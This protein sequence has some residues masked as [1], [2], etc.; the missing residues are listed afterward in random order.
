MVL[1]VLQLVANRNR[2]KSMCNLVR[3][4]VHSDYRA[5]WID[6]HCVG[7]DGSRKINRRVS[8]AGLQETV[9]HARTVFKIAH[10]IGTG[11]YVPSLCERAAG[12]VK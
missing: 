9:E 4:G 6:T 7:S 1:I 10:D 3:V 11:I 8:V 5:S 12:H 2:E